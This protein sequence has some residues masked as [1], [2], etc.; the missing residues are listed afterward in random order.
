ML[1]PHNKTKCSEKRLLL[2]CFY[3]TF[4]SLSEC[5]LNAFKAIFGVKSRSLGSS[6]HRSV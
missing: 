3:T 5:H 1:S 4:V 6:G 2:L